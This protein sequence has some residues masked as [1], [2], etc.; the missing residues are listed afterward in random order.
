MLHECDVCFA[1]SGILIWKMLITIQ[2]AQE[3]M[4]MRQ[5]GCEFVSN[6]EENPV[7]LSEN[8]VMDGKN[9]VH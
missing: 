7:I 8:W 1:T 6:P 4:V 9:G 5:H 3:F 2:P